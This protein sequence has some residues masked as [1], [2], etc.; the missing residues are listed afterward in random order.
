MPK[1]LSRD[2]SG[3]NVLSLATRQSHQLLLDRLPADQALAEE[4]RSPACALVHV[5][6]ADVVAIAV[7]DE[8]RHAGTPWIV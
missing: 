6:V 7:A 4:E 5:D 8:V 2:G 1:S 3:N